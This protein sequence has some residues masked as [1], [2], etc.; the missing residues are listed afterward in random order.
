MDVHVVSVSVNVDMAVIVRGRPALPSRPP[1][2]S[3]QSPVSLA[4]NSSGQGHAGVE[5]EVNRIPVPFHP[6]L[7]SP[8]SSTFHPV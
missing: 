3:L 8:P 4:L 6:S 7:S 1:L 5:S 2:P